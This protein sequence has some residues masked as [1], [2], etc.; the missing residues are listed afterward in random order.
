LN[1]PQQSPLALLSFEVETFSFTASKFIMSSTADPIVYPPMV[2]SL[3]GRA[4]TIFAGD[5]SYFC[6]EDDLF[7]F[8]APLGRVLNVSIARKNEASLMYGFV[9]FESLETAEKIAQEYNGYL[10][11]GRHLR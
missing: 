8:F 3:A 1:Q 7:R 6:S 5:L 4:R 11:M 9:E 2:S 10:F